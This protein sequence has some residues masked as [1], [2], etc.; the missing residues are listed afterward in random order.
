M[1]D[2]MN[3]V[4]SLEECALLRKGASETIENESKKQNCEFLNM[5]FGILGASLLGNALT[6][7]ELMM[8]LSELVKEQLEW[9]RIFNAVS[10]FN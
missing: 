2:I 9:N 10:S 4:K 5:F 3:I 1:K 7:K 8:E 6:G